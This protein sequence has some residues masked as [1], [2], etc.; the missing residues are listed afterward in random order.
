MAS[1]NGKRA[2]LLRVHIDECLTEV[3][4]CLLF[5]QILWESSFVEKGHDFL[6]S[7][8]SECLQ[9]KRAQDVLTRS[10]GIS[11]ASLC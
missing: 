7:W 9:C 6:S 10:V 11:G 8:V 3:E 1:A 4:S 5:L 2:Y